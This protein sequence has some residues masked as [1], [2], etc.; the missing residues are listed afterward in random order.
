M[1]PKPLLTALASAAVLALVAALGWA[2][3]AWWSSRLP[4]SYSVMDYGTLDGGGGPV[5]EHSAHTGG[6]SVAALHGP[7]GRPDARFTLTA[8]RTPIRLGSD[9]TIDALT[10]NGRSPGPELRVQRG[11][12]VEVTLLNRDV[13]SGVTIHWHGVDVPNAEDGVAGVTQDAVLPG[14]RYTYRFRVNQEG[15]FWYHTHQVSSKDVKRGLFGALVIEPRGPRRAGLDLLAIA[16]DFAGVPTIN[17]VDGIERRAVRPGTPV[18]LR[19]VNSDSTPQRFVLA[20]TRFRVVAVDGT[21]L[22]ASPALRGRTLELAGGGRY[23]VEFTM[24]ERPVGLTLVGGKTALALSADGMAAPPPPEPGP[25]LDLTSYGS[26]EQSIAPESPFDRTF[27][28]EI[29]RKPGF[30]DGD[31]GMHWAING[32]LFPDAPVFV[33]REGDL[34]KMTIQN[35]TG[36][37][38]PM[39]LHG[40]HVFVLSHNGQPVATPWWSDTLNVEADESYEVAFRADNPGVWLNHCHNLPHA[41]EGFVMHV[42]YEGVHTPFR[43]GGGAHNHPE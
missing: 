43:V 16:H 10:F 23:D 41:A 29:D 31:P 9:R 12:L 19:L 24:P 36:S 4:E 38:H 40:H 37:V 39:H 5:A 22:E 20:G 33:V 25:E 2:G 7:R 27:R 35:D 26:P 8:Q 3:H 14:G 21:E 18:R 6:V 30:V 1:F 28:L 34:V 15:T 13:E 11:D 17:G 32:K 42:A